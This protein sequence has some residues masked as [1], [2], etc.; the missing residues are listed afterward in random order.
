M[1]IDKVGDV[2]NTVRYDILLNIIHA[3]VSNYIL[4]TVYIYIHV[5]IDRFVMEIFETFIQAVG[6][7][8][9]KYDVTQSMIRYGFCMILHGCA[10]CQSIC[11]RWAK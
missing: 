4:Y 2:I 9:M 7:L 3:H 10:A 8:G 5:F 1:T 6:L 11:Q